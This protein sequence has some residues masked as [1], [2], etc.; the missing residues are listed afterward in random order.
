MPAPRLLRIAANVVCRDDAGRLLLARRIGPEG[1]QWTMPGGGLEFGEHPQVAALR[2][3]AEETGYDG[4]VEALLGVDAEH[5]SGMHGADMHAVRVVYRGRV[6]GG[7]LH[8]EVG[9]TTDQAAWIPPAELD[10]LDAVS[11]VRASIHLDELPGVPVGPVAADPATRSARPRAARVAAYAIVRDDAGAVLLVRARSGTTWA[12]S[13]FLPGGGLVH[14]EQPVD[15][16][17][18]EILEETGLHVAVRGLSAVT[19]DVVDGAARNSLLWTVRLVYAADVVGGTLRP[20]IGGSTDRVEWVGLDE[21][22]GL[23]LM[24]FV[25]ETLDVGPHS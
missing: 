4:Q 17:R 21:L 23:P 5:F 24:P 18:R 1:P 20:E 12:G 2:E 14:G 15:A 25:R 8:H 19:S 22:G 9:G 11:L 6:V 10:C 7:A 16:I 13:W 3:L